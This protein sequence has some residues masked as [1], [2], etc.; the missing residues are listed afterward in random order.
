MIEKSGINLFNIRPTTHQS[1]I[2]KKLNPRYSEAGDDD[3]QRPEIYTE[4]Q[5]DQGGRRDVLT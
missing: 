1:S 3:V 5:N 4:D 2:R